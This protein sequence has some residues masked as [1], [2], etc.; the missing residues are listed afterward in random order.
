MDPS[1]SAKVTQ[2]HDKNSKIVQIVTRMVNVNSVKKREEIVEK[3]KCYFFDLNG[4]LNSHTL[5]YICEA[6]DVCRNESKTIALLKD[7]FNRNCKLTNIV[8]S[9]A[10]KKYDVLETRQKVLLSFHL[11][12]DCRLCSE[13]YTALG[14]VGDFFDVSSECVVE[15]T[16]AYF[17][18]CCY[19]CDYCFKNKLYRKLSRQFFSYHL[20]LRSPF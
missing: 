14:G 12:N 4:K 3:V 20:M 5:D 10:L 13:C 8:A 7:S 19:I 16:N 18:C 15:P 6:F 17:F 11:V 9:A 2:R 1:T